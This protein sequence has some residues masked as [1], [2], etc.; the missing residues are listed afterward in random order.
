MFWEYFKHNFAEKPENSR[1]FPRIL[2]NFQFFY[3]KTAILERNLWNFHCFALKFQENLLF[4]QKIQ[5][6]TGV[7][8]KIQPFKMQIL[9][10][11]FLKVQFLQKKVD[12]K[13]F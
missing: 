13:L 4:Q 3:Q 6:K 2:G 1:I 9:K 8:K 5:K 12:S 7:F 11:L 10:I